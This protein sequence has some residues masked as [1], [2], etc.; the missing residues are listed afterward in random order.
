[1]P[2]TFPGD[3]SKLPFSCKDTILDLLNPSDP[4]HK[5]TT[6]GVPSSKIVIGAATY[7]RGYKLSEAA[8]YKYPVEELPGYLMHK[9]GT[10]GD[11]DQSIASYGYVA[12]QCTGPD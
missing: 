10:K 11:L 7:Q 3:P 6:T 8:G 1:M 12:S 4:N 9:S 2:N 5:W